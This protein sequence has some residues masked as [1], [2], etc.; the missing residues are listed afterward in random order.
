[1]SGEI[2]GRPAWLPA[3]LYPF[4][5]HWAEIDGN[6]VHYLDE[7]DGPPLLLL[8][9]NPSW[10]FG[11]RGIIERLRDRFRCV[12]PDYPGFGLSRAAAGYDY[13]P[14][15]HSRIVETL[16]DRLGLDG[17]TIMG[18]DWGGPIGLWLAGRRPAR[19]RALVIGNTWAWPATERG[20]RFWS[21][22]MGGPL[23]PLL[24]DRLNLF[25]KVALPGGIKRRKLSEPELAAYHGPF[26]RGARQPMRIFPREIVASRR[27]LRQ[28][29]AGL[30]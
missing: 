2:E 29:E 10:S 26:P 1:M 14:A 6:N 17:L 18:Y 9:G 20:M 3:E 11:Y 21:A 7:G 4:A 16:V 19:T 5:D 15:S 13:R 28:V 12:A 8:S 23:S 30:A 25:L 24:V 22:L 27:Y